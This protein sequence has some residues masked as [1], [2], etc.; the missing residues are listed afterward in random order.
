MKISYTNTISSIADNIKSTKINTGKILDVI[1]SDKIINK[2]YLK[3]GT[4][5]SGPCFQ[6]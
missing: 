6:G 1:G 5:F 3:L 2:Q 4:M